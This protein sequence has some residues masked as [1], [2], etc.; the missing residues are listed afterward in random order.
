MRSKLRAIEFKKQLHI[1]IIGKARFYTGLIIGILFLLGTIGNSLLNIQS[2]MFIHN[3]L[4]FTDVTH[5]FVHY[6]GLVAYI[7]GV[8]ILIWFLNARLQ[9]KDKARY[10]RFGITQIFIYLV[11]F[12]SSIFNTSQFTY[13]PVK[14]EDMR[15]MLAGPY[16]DIIKFLIAPL[17]FYL[18]WNMIR[19]AY[20]CRKFIFINLILGI[21]FATV[22]ILL[23]WL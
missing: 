3:H 19:L 12:N 14:F 11:L 23:H 1:E 13:N 6:F 17:L 21:C 15:V 22:C 16:L 20:N 18:S 4:S 7:S 8:V 2:G 9:V 5:L 10:I